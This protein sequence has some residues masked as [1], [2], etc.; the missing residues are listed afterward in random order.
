MTTPA[1]SPEPTDSGS[2]DRATFDGQVHMNHIRDALWDDSTNGAVV[3]VGAGFSRNAV[4][5]PPT[6]GTLPLWTD[7]ATTLSQRL[8]PQ[9]E[10]LGTSQQAVSETVPR[11]AQEYEAA[12]GRT[13]LHRHLRDAI[14]DEDF[15]PGALHESLLALPWRD[16][17]TT[18][19]D[20]LLERANGTPSSQN[21]RV[22]SCAE[23]IPLARSPRIVK[24]HGS[25]P[26]KFPLIATEEDY[27]RY[28][29]DFA[30]FVN[31]VQQAMLESVVCLIGFSGDD[32]NFHQW[33]GWVRDNL[34]SHAWKL[35][36]LGW[37][38]LTPHRRRM[39]EAR[40]VIPV[41]LA[42]HP[43]APKWPEQDRQ[44]L[45]TEWI[46]RTLEL[47]RPYD[48]TDWPQPPPE[49]SDP[50][51]ML[52]PVSV[53]SAV[54][55]REPS[56]PPRQ[57]DRDSLT[58]AELDN[59]LTV[60]ARNRV[61]YPG[62]LT[63]PSS[64]RHLVQDSTDDWE[65]P[66]LAFLSRLPFRRKLRAVYELVWRRSIL[67]DPP[68]N[69]LQ[70][71]CEHIVQ[72]PKP[73]ELFRH[74]IHHAE[75]TSPT[76]WIQWR[77]IVSFLLTAARL[78]FDEAEF[79]RLLSLLAPW[80][81]KDPHV[82]QVRHH[83]RSLWA[84]YSLDHERLASLLERWSTDSADIVWSMRK[85]SLLLEIN[86][87]GIAEKTLTDA[88]DTLRKSDHPGQI[89][90]NASRESWLLVSLLGYSFKGGQLTAS[91]IW[92]RWREFGR[93]RCDAGI[94]KSSF[95][96][97]MR[98]AVERNEAAPFDLDRIRIQGVGWSSAEYERWRAAQR[99]VRLCEVAGIPPRAWILG[100][101]SELMKAAVDVLI[102]SEMELAARLSL[103]I[104]TYDRDKTLTR[105]FSRS[106]VATM[107]KHVVQHLQD[108]C[109][110]TLALYVEGVGRDGEQR[111][112]ATERVGIAMECLSRLV[113]RLDPQSVSG[114]AGNAL[115]LYGRSSIASNRLLAEPM[116][117]L[118]SRCWESLSEDLREKHLFSFLRAPILD[119]DGFVGGDLYPDASVGIDTAS[120][121]PIRT[122]ES[123]EE[124]KAVAE[125]II[126]GIG[127]GGAA[128]N[129]AIGRAYLVSSWNCFGPEEAAEIAELLWAPE[130][131]MVAELPQGA[132]VADWVLASLPEPE[133]GFAERRFW[134]KV[135]RVDVSGGKESVEIL[136][137]VSRFLDISR[138]SNR[139]VELPE[140]AH[141]KLVAHVE[142]WAKERSQARFLFDQSELDASRIRGVR[143]L[144]NALLEIQ[145]PDGVADLL[146]E[147][148]VFMKETPVSAL[149]LVAGVLQGQPQH[150]EDA[151]LLIQTCLAAD[152]TQHAEGAIWGIFGWIRGIE[153]LPE[154]FPAIPE[155]LIREVGN[156][157]ASRRRKILRPA[158]DVAAWIVG[159][160]PRAQAELVASLAIHGL[161]P[162]LEELRYERTHED[163]DDVPALRRN[164]VR[165][166]IALDERGWGDEAPVR[167]WISE[168]ATDPLPE[169]RF[170]RNWELWETG[171]ENGGAADT[172]SSDSS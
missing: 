64:R 144:W 171:S 20:T 26:S 115:D 163:R 29:T 7:L 92:N 25:L 37:H 135:G 143:A 156:I 67:L 47:G 162:L 161:G 145:I 6:E 68:S 152:S 141:Q 88:L 1:P 52:Q 91:S 53:V 62:W 111:R 164:C 117:N 99:G 122:A 126:R 56:A 98:P 12:F 123:E 130:G 23:E 124:W 97:A 85:A 93:L 114:A 39:L 168:A 158:L 32:P 55:E 54:P 118:L 18:N 125:L 107:P 160:A 24:L 96:D 89:I 58:Q 31:M 116:Q 44:R 73:E 113:V 15:L 153:L 119:L 46:L 17:F 103:R 69:E 127:A 13:E 5:R 148:I 82:R 94:E 129:R 112:F 108:M 27:R 165:L 42:R 48:R 83:E 169:V 155:E 35:Y 172:K 105:V 140:Q 133:P 77:T 128:R 38:D 61:L 146:Y 57:K 70:N 136:D 100:V 142:A 154:R 121:S 81:S 3:L 95:L 40:N 59:I 90:A 28:P 132:G 74:G 30:A 149:P 80:E 102:G 166:A 101:G 71:A 21:Y 41:D 8:S 151:K 78:R 10:G 65:G 110:G 75:A 150:H 147:K 84:A 131:Q 16:V 36:L 43:L 72:T 76:A 60:W 167:T 49:P 86:Q 66:I 134:D 22:V 120:L 45:A 137:E 33:H 138:R 9:P 50:E 139:T 87:E 51:P 106:R 2:P 4:S 79:D 63:V 14:R 11:L 170:A 104:A 34:G 159:N 19:W 109:N 157:V